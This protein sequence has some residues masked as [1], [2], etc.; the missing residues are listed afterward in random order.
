VIDLNEAIARAQPALQQ[1]VH[2][3]GARLDETFIEG[4]VGKLAQHI[5]RACSRSVVARS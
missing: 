4:C 1:R 5:W 2:Q 3:Q